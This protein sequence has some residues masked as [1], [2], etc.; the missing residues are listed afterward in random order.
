MNRRKFG[1]ALGTVVAGLTAGAALNAQDDNRSP[2]KKT[3]VP[4]TIAK[5]RTPAKARAAA[6]LATTAA[7]ART[8]ARARA[9]AQFLRKIRS[10]LGFYSASIPRPGGLPGLF[11]I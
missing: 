3:K 9:A 8:P 4:N 1:I 2:T 6:R 5:A 11:A 10:K 7:P